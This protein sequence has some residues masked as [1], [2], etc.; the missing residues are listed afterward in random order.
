VRYRLRLRLSVPGSGVIPDLAV[1]GFQLADG[2]QVAEAGV[3]GG[4]AG[5]GGDRGAGPGLAQQELGQ[6]RFSP[7]AQGQV[8]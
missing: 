6:P 1:A 2:F 4:P 7:S 8:R 5:Q 3:F